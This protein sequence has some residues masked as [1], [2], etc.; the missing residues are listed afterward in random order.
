MASPAEQKLG[1]VSAKNITPFCAAHLI[2]V[3]GALPGLQAGHVAHKA[4]EGW[5]ACCAAHHQHL[6]DGGP[7]PWPH[8]HGTDC[9]FQPVLGKTCGVLSEVTQ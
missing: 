5:H 6:R 9:G 1:H 7:P 2:R 8:L 3:N 4:P